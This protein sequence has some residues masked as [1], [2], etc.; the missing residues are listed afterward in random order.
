[1]QCI[2]CIAGNVGQLHH[3]LIHNGNLCI[4]IDDVLMGNGGL[5]RVI[6]FYVELIGTWLWLG[7]GGFGFGDRA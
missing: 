2:K 7:L 3:V 5:F 1:M 4:R 6:G